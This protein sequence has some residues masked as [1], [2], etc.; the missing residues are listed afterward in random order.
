MKTEEW[1]TE[2]VKKQFQVRF[3]KELHIEDTKIVKVYKDVACVYV[4][5]SLNR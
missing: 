5:C 4:I 2:S 3:G 1:V